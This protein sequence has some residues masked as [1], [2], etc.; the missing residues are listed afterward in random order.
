[1][2]KTSPFIDIPIVFISALTKQRIFDAIKI[3]MEVNERRNHKIPT[4]K[5]NDLLLPIIEQKPPP[6]TKGKYVKIKFCRQLPT[7]YPQFAF[8]CN[9]P[10]YI[11]DPYKRFLEN[12]IRKHYNFAGVPI[13][14]FIRKK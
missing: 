1:M 13:D 11:K 3:A 14:V 9:L 4:K 8:Y 10:Q 2:T 7:K 6:S 12:Q 5:L